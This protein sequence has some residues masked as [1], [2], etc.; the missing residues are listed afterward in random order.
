MNTLGTKHSPTSTLDEY[1]ALL[2]E[3]LESDSSDEERYQN[4]IL[5]SRNLAT[6]PT[7]TSRRPIA[8]DLDLDFDQTHSSSRTTQ[9]VLPD[10]AKSSNSSTPRNSTDVQSI[11]QTPVSI[12][13][14]SD[15]LDPLPINIS[16]SSS[17]AHTSSFNPSFLS[18]SPT[19]DR[20]LSVLSLSAPSS[21]SSSPSSS[22]NTLTRASSVASSSAQRGQ[23]LD[24][25]SSLK[26]ILDS[27]SSLDVDSALE[28]PTL[29]SNYLANLSFIRRSDP[30]K[31]ILQTKAHHQG[32]IH[33][34]E[35][36][37]ARFNHRNQALLSNG[38]KMDMNIQS[39]RVKA[40]GNGTHKNG[41][42]SQ[43][44]APIIL[45]GSN[46]RL[47]NGLQSITSLEQQFLELRIP[48]LDLLNTPETTIKAV[49]AD[50]Y[51]I[52][53]E[54]HM[55][56]Q[57][58]P[59][60]D[61]PIQSKKDGSGI[62]I[63]GETQRQ[64]RIKEI[65]DRIVRET[66]L[67]E[68][69]VRNSNYLNL[70]AILNEA[71]DDDEEELQ[72]FGNLG[73]GTS[74]MDSASDIH[75]EDTLSQTSLMSGHQYGH[76]GA[77]SLPSSPLSA[78]S[79]R[80][81]AE[82]LHRLRPHPLSHVGPG[83][84]ASSSAI[85]GRQSRTSSIS[86]SVSGINNLSESHSPGP[87]AGAEPWETFRWT[88]LLKL[89]DQLFSDDIKASSGLGTCIAVS[90]IIAVG[91]SRGSI[92]VYST[93][94]SLMGIFGSP[95]YA[96]EH[97]SVCSI[98][99]S[100][101]NTYM[102]AGHSLGSV[103]VWN[104]S[105]PNAPSRIIPPIAKDVA[106]SGR[107]LGHIRGSAVLNVGFVG[108]KRAEIVSA[109]DQGMSF[110]HLLYK[111]M[112]VNAVETT[113]L[114]GKYPTPKF[115]RGYEVRGAVGAP[116]QSTV[117]GMGVLPYGQIPHPADSAGLV[118][119]LTPFKM[120]IVCVK[121][122]PQTLF[123]FVRPKELQSREGESS[124]V[125]SG[126]LAWFP[127][128]KSQRGQGQDNEIVETNP[129]LAFSWNRHLYIF[130]VLKSS[131]QSQDSGP[132]LLSPDRKAVPE[133][134][135]KSPKL[136]FVKIGDWICREGIVGIQ[137]VRPQILLLLTNTEDIIV[138]DPKLMCETERC[139][140]RPLQI[141]YH[142]W[143]R[144][145][146]KVHRPPAAISSVD[147]KPVVGDMS[148]NNS[149]RVHKGKLFVLGVRRI[150]VG[151]ILNWTDRILALV[152]SG[153]FLEGIALATLFY[154]GKSIQ[155]AVVGLPEDEATRKQ[156]VGEKIYEL[157]TASLNYTFNPERMMDVDADAAAGGVG[158]GTVLF[159]DLAIQAIETCLSIDDQDFLFED[160]YDRYAEASTLV[161]GIFLQSLEGYILQDRLTKMPP[162]VMQAFVKY[163]SDRGMYKA[164]ELCICHTPCNVLEMDKIVDLCQK[165]QL[166]NGLI[167]VWNKSINDYV[168]PV[169]ELLRVIKS[170]LK[171]R[172]SAGEHDE[173]GSDQDQPNSYIEEST[174]SRAIMEDKPA[175]PERLSNQE[176][177]QKLYGY[178]ADSLLG[179]SYID[180]TKLEPAE[181]VAAKV[182]LYSFIFSGRCVMWPSIGGQLILT[183]DA[184]DADDAEPTYP[185]LKLFLKHDS[186]EFLKVIDLAFEDSYLSSTNRDFSQVARN[187]QDGP[188]R[189]MSR[190]LI[191]NTLLEVL[192]P[193]TSFSNT[194][195]PDMNGDNTRPQE[196]YTA[197]D[198]AHLYSFIAR[199]Y[200]KSP[201]ALALSPTTLHRILTRLSSDTDPSTREE[202]QV[203][204][205]A[206][207][208]CYSPADEAGMMTLY[209]E[210]GFYR[211]L[212]KMYRSQ[213]Q[214]GPM[215]VTFLKDPD[216]RPLVFEAIQK[217]LDPTRPQ[218][219]NITEKQRTDIVKTA[220]EHIAEIVDIDGEQAALLVHRYLNA[221]HR[222]VLE[223]LHGSK[224]RLFAYLRGLLEPSNIPAADR[225]PVMD[226]DYTLGSHSKMENENGR[227]IGAS[228]ITDPEI[229]EQYVEL[230]CQYDPSGVYDY[231]ERH[232]DNS[233]RLEKVL[234]LCENAGVVDA[235]V[236]IM[237]R[238][239]NVGGALSKVL[240]IVQ[241]RI[242]MLA[243][244]VKSKE[245]GKAQDM[246]WSMEEQSNMRAS[247]VRLRGVLNVG[248]QLCERRSQKIKIL[249]HTTTVPAQSKSAVESD[250]ETL[251]FR[252]LQVFVAASRKMTLLITS[253]RPGDDPQ[254]DEMLP[255]V[256][257][258][259]NLLIEN[260]PPAL[261][262]NSSPES[263]HSFH[264]IDQLS[265]NFKG[266]VQSILATLLLSTSTP[267]VSL[268]SLL[269]RLLRSESAEDGEL[270]R[271]SDF[272]DIF[273]GM[274]DTFKYEGQLLEMT[275]NLF[276][277]DLFLGVQLIAKTRAKGWRPR[278]GNCEICGGAFWGPNI[279]RELWVQQQRAAASAI[280]A[281]L[282]TSVTTSDSGINSETPSP[283][284]QT[285]TASNSGAAMDKEKSLTDKD[286]MLFR[287]GHGYHRQCLEMESAAT[288]IIPSSGTIQNQH[289]QLPGQSP[290]PVPRI[291]S[292]AVCNGQ[293]KAPRPRSSSRPT[294][295]SDSRQHHHDHHR[296]HSSQR[297]SKS[298]KGG[299]TTIESP[300]PRASSQPSRMTMV[301]TPSPPPP[302][303]PA[304]D[305]S[306]TTPNRPQTP[307]DGQD[308]DGYESPGP[309]GHYQN[310]NEYEAATS[311]NYYLLI[312]HKYTTDTAFFLR[313]VNIAEEEKD[314]K[315]EQQRQ[316]GQVEMG[317]IDEREVRAS[318]GRRRGAGT[319]WNVASIANEPT[320][321]NKKSSTK[322]N[323]SGAN[324]DHDSEGNTTHDKRSRA[325]L[326]GANAKVGNVD[327]DIA[328]TRAKFKV[329]GPEGSDPTQIDNDGKSSVSRHEL[330]TGTET[331]YRKNDDSAPTWG[332]GSKLWNKI[333]S[334]F[335]PSELESAG[336]ASKEWHSRIFSL[337]VWQ[338]ICE[339]AGLALPAAELEAQG[340]EKPDY[341]TLAHRN[342]EMICEKCY[343]MTRPTSSFRALPVAV[344]EPDALKMIHMC[345][346]CRVDYY[347][348]HP[349]S[350]PDDVAPYKAGRYTV[351]PR[352]TKGDAKKTYLLSD[353]D[354]MS[355]PYEI[356]RNPYFGNHSPMY[357]FEEQHVLRLARQ[358]HG[359]SVG[360]VAARADS[361]NAGRKI[362]EPH[363]AVVK[364]RRNLLRSMLHDER[365][366]LPEHV[367]IC[368]IYI[369]TG[370]GDP[371]EIVKELKVVDWFHRCT[372]YD[373]SLNKTHLQQVKRRPRITRDRETLSVNAGDI[374]AEL[375]N[376]EVMSEEEEDDDQHKIAALDDW[377]THRLEQGL[378][379][380]YR[381]D[382]DTPERP[383]KALWPMLDKVGMPHKMAEFAAEKVYKVLEK[384]K[385]EL[386][387]QDAFE[388]IVKSKAQVRDIVDAPQHGSSARGSELSRRKRRKVE[389]EDE[390][391]GDDESTDRRGRGHRDEP[392]LSTIMEHDFGSDWHMEII[393]RAK[394]MV[395]SRLF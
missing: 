82:P 80:S 278:K 45:K 363:D 34:H 256:T 386:Q 40:R 319:G 391:E 148:Y 310:S 140:G 336:S 110:Y 35:Q 383:P 175:Q 194:S 83:S 50:I 218:R 145:V 164:L 127:A 212:E 263:Q 99:I 179:K 279:V 29:A 18:T 201:K 351:T 216:R 242:D 355:L 131:G 220:M 68:E 296:H 64:K 244:L 286:L 235:V 106:V 195:I 243:G 316:E 48:E 268:P 306:T 317:K 61:A 223:T 94:Q 238:S 208:R 392:K 104:I 88:P 31:D 102:V 44:S 2:K 105:K 165:H 237:E 71:S 38:A 174:L 373:P 226:G 159:H 302:P 292:C 323:S 304:K 22:V 163:Y 114:L 111:V 193:S 186:E 338:E 369:E 46:T 384:N 160:V 219:I 58:G 132:A 380:S 25:P 295:R 301:V 130:Q 294:S 41:K 205:Q 185:Y 358:V 217:L 157:L 197:K 283:A 158:A 222:S 169:V 100:S 280:K 307:V 149:W 352:M 357:L 27:S 136:D 312:Y 390:A 21:A 277:R 115:A 326:I 66:S 120:L 59:L 271:F 207:L 143:F 259:S 79:F 37:L 366:H 189:V 109:D 52:S 167:Y 96:L 133:V 257:P 255:K 70:D 293:I 248:K 9:S 172:Q 228:A 156:V 221:E 214:Y 192:T 134:N 341:F 274:L 320:K 342:A 87:G 249:S 76:V 126:N 289:L 276:E 142:D 368:N 24:N 62:V 303:P 210:A 16:S 241:E 187:G 54:L 121:P 269:R 348:E 85:T 330:K 108:I 360:I 267:Q 42:E 199:N 57:G 118:A 63:S 285:T 84:V 12:V 379:R 252:L 202:R 101:D 288:P 107:K 324:R 203:A 32:I 166:Y 321:Q 188:G 266:F 206:L 246:Y 39:S 318:G 350:I 150:Q 385:N 264:V 314:D 377:L 389:S 154:T 43:S 137:W 287:C 284:L 117:F 382:P 298:I 356:G 239:G 245:D 261:F 173:N 36:R 90:N 339:K 184:D 11:K 299:W 17:S 93:T 240:E 346:D 95:Q 162:Q 225:A 337:P 4:L 308:A 146:A 224:P 147:S 75:R 340:R 55:H 113:R 196:E 23:Y 328:M 381:S 232:Q 215:V 273:L 74:E 138:F 331:E 26:T 372:S 227:L 81:V 260:A 51:K 234:K 7:R 375:V 139:S 20:S 388:K 116:R 78:L 56:L 97:G 183:R 367:A 354:V 262:S 152:K 233:Y 124:A 333:Y 144:D 1:E 30:P 329:E 395:K 347:V 91:T 73:G 291:L 211:V 229:H 311:P 119:L 198:M 89:S 182:S 282:S 393:K 112:M 353:S 270:N 315:Q 155:A 322:N 364:H 236:W 60:A 349:E 297:S 325:G 103:I 365:L 135:G 290:S 77:T 10:T 69:F 129:M 191:I 371:V 6:S 345:R 247:L 334:S 370:L 258:S 213:K 300:T 72:G 272:K 374:A 343:K 361:E 123:K 275:N 178:L 141:V 3:I 209:T 394:E 313:S 231:L 359:G 128:A 170:I 362:P 181:A 190:Q 281:A 327:S 28:H 92:L 67:Y 387:R 332:V 200:A 8:L 49:L 168:S 98:A 33:R 265:N 253:S 180:G 125:I 151:T 344:T 153:D 5:S 53:E 14:G 65:L 15:K 19:K 122:Q 254:D 378:Y 305:V 335:Y 86:F 251:W 250:T 204:V 230:L 171:E 376:D 47:V 177:V 309:G 13:V 161:R 176:I